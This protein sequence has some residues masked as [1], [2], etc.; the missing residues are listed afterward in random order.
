MKKKIHM[1]ILKGEFKKQY[2][3]IIPESCPSLKRWDKKNLKV[4]HMFS[5]HDLSFQETKFARISTDICENI[6]YNIFL[7]KEYTV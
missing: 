2:L 5:M 1:T 6:L 4:P 7:M 3:N